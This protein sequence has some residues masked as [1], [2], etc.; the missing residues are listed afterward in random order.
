[1]KEGNAV[2]LSELRFRFPRSGLVEQET[3]DGIP[4]AWISKDW[5]HEALGWLK[6]Q[7]PKPY[8]FFFDLTAVDDRAIRSKGAEA[9]GPGAKKRKGLYA[10]LSSPVV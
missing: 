6:V 3:V 2:I 1:M 10:H 8:P 4:T 7:I 9:N 5:V